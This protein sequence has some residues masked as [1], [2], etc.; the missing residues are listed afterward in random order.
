MAMKHRFGLA[1][2]V[3]A[4]ALF[5]S[6]ARATCDLVPI[7]R[8][9]FGGLELI[10]ACSILPFSAL[11]PGAA[12]I[13]TGLP[14]IAPQEPLVNLVARDMLYFNWEIPAP[15]V[16]RLESALQLPARGFRIAPIEIIRGEAPR[17]YLSLN[18]Y[19]TT[20]AGVPT[21]RT[22]WATYV[23][24]QGD[25]RPRYLVIDVQSSQPGAD[26]TYPGFIKPAT[27]VS[28]TID[29]RRVQ[30]SSADYQA[31]FMRP[32]PG[33]EKTVK[34]GRPWALA[35]DALYWTNGVADTA[36]YN[37]I[38]IDASPISVNPSS[39]AVSNASPWAAFIS[40]RPSNILL[41]TE[42]LEFAF[43]P[44]FNLADPGLGLP[45]AYTQALQQ[46]KRFTF[47][48]FSY[49]HAFQVLEGLEEPLLRFD[50]TTDKVPSIFIN[51]SIPNQNVRAFEAALRLPAN[52]E[53]AKTKAT[54]SQP[55]RYLLSLNIYESPDVLTGA[56]VSR[57]EWS[58]Y[59][60]DK[61]GPQADRYFFM[62]V[63][64]DSSGPSLNPVDLF[65]PPTVMDYR[66]QNGRITADIKRTVQGG[67]VS[68]KFFVDFGMPAPSASAVR[69]H[70]PWILANDRIYWRNGVY[71]SLF[72]N[73]SLLE[74]D[75][76]AAD[77][78]SLTIRDQT[79]W[80]RFVD[81]APVEV[82]VFR[83]PLQF[84]LHPWYNVE[85]LCAASG[86]ATG[87]R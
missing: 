37:R 50:V 53:L 36:L 80:A 31:S 70:E 41:F 4:L 5:A 66:L 12:D 56:R 85:E 86:G 69:L 65:T 40:G 54:G 8:Q 35:N 44:Y 3:V 45:P 67:S 20:I 64:V 57:A 34:I 18:Y 43:T 75:V 25:P 29:G 60:K 22:E 72:Y 74:A 38:L 77:T 14:T 47:G 76:V 7:K 39:A 52:F 15:N 6:T 16:S 9:N 79:P 11:A 82:L 83:K 30:V 28:Y 87:G 48:A 71:D 17:P 27:P 46:F 42:P 24:K 49:G 58:T 61:N 78:G 33:G 51:F 55:A 59:V 19:A 81:A 84:V 13:C 1:S 21:Y 32:A 2:I 68:D 73:G 23:V 26:P 10:R 63:D 62:V